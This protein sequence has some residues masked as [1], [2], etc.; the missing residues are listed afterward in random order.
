MCRPSRRQ[1]TCRA[2]ISVVPVLPALQ[3]MTASAFWR[4][5]ASTTC[6]ARWR[7]GT[8]CAS[9]PSW[10]GRKGRPSTCANEAGRTRTTPTCPSTRRP[11]S[12][13]T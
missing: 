7:P 13:R 1:T 10:A 12:S 3:A 5:S 4:R 9:T 6:D 8:T 11:S 2:S